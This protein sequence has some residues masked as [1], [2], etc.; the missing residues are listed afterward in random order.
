MKIKATYN[1]EKIEFKSYAEFYR[2]TEKNNLFASKT[3][4]NGLNQNCSK[5]VFTQKDKSELIICK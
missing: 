3:N 2:W 1:N 5:V 4:K